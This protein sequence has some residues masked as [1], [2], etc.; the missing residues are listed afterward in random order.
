MNCQSYLRL[1]NKSNPSRNTYMCSIPLELWGVFL[2]FSLYVFCSWSRDISTK[3]CFWDCCRTTCKRLE[4]T[5]F[6]R[7]KAVV[8][9]LCFTH[10]RQTNVSKLVTCASL[11]WVITGEGKGYGFPVHCKNKKAKGT[12]FCDCCNLELLERW[13]KIRVLIKLYAEGRDS[14]KSTKESVL[15]KFLKNHVRSWAMP[16]LHETV[17]TIFNTIYIIC[18]NY[19][20]YT[21]CNKRH[22]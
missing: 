21:L 18:P 11:G 7:H 9:D 2:V 4:R 6:I 8:I 3:N 1:N 17:I 14:V 5:C 12:C 19:G 10:V 13:R 16:Y 15:H 20:P 22:I